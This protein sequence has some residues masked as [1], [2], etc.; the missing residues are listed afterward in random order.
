MGR[1]KSD[2]RQENGVSERAVQ[3][4]DFKVYFDISG[5]ERGVPLSPTSIL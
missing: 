3:R 4:H 1:W 5:F 2:G